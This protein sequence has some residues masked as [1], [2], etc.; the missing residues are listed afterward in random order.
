MYFI[1][2]LRV[3]LAAIHKVIIYMY[4][5][6]S[7]RVKLAV[8]HEVIFR[9]SELTMASTIASSAAHNDHSINAVFLLMIT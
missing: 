1:Y 2:S 3:K 5:I 8:I 7:L 6:Y 4:F 9:S